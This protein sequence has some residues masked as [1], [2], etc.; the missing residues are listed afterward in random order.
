MLHNPNFVKQV[1]KRIMINRIHKNIN[2]DY[3]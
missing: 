1:M 2:D 3:F